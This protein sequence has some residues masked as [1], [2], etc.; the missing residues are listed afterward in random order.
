[1]YHDIPHLIHPVV[2]QAKDATKALRWAVEEM[3][4]RYMLLSD[5]GV[6]NIETYNRKIVKDTK[7]VPADT[8]KRDRQNASLYNRHH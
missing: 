4:R 5:R 6:R 7:T 1:M 8:S 2:T 3:E